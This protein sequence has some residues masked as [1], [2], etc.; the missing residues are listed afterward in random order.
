MA[1]NVARGVAI[2]LEP[3]E[4]RQFRRLLVVSALAHTA[5]AFFLG[6]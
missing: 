3:F 2:S 5:L 4:R 1:K 6:F